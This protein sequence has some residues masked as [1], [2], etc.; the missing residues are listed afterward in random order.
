VRPIP[1]IDYDEPK[2]D[3]E[4]DRELERISPRNENVSFFH[5]VWEPGDP[6]SP[7]GRWVVY[8]MLHGQWIPDWIKVQLDG[9]NPRSRGRMKW[10][11]VPSAIRGVDGAYMK[12]PVLEYEPSGDCIIS[13][14]QWLL[15]R[16]TGCYGNP[17]WI[18]QG[19]QGGHLRR[20]SVQESKASML[21]GGPTEPPTIGDLPYA[22][23][24]DRVWSRLRRANEMAMRS[25]LL[26][27]AEKMPDQ[28]MEM[29]EAEQA[30]RDDLTWDEKAERKALAA[31][32]GIE[33]DEAEGWAGAGTAGYSGQLLTRF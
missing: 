32:L 27:M 28:F 15:Y 20:W 21:F 17:F 25:Q 10:K 26:A 31:W 14:R 5:L 30:E 23:P 29:I 19:D 7:V 22:E 33:V 16:E 24:D 1:V 18:I 6:W 2:R 9:E 8:Q 11:S 3:P 13:M 4:W 12:K